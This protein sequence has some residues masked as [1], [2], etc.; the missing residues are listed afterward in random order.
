VFKCLKDSSQA[1]KPLLDWPD[2]LENIV[3]DMHG[4]GFPIALFAKEL[5]LP[6][7]SDS[8]KT[9]SNHEPAHGF[10]SHRAQHPPRHDF[11]Q[12]SFQDII[13]LDEELNQTFFLTMASIS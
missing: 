8:L 2:G 3:R 11:N 4:H 10:Q 12:F 1:H 5:N 9:L 13:E 6:L 7:L